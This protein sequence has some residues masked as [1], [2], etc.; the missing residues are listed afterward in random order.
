VCVK[1][2]FIS[3]C[4][5]DHKVNLFDHKVIQLRESEIQVALRE[6]ISLWASAATGESECRQDLLRDKQRIVLSFFHYI[7]KPPSEVDPS[8]VQQWLRGLEGKEI[9]P[10]TTYQHACL[11]G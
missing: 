11:W 1:P 3:W 5:F 9:K 4:R 2:P 6:A 8:D 10:G 7:G